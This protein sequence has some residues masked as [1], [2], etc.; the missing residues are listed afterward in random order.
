MIRIQVKRSFWHK[1]SEFLIPTITAPNP[2]Y[3][4]SLPNI[5]YDKYFYNYQ[6]R[7]LKGIRNH[8]YKNLGTTISSNYKIGNI[9]M[10]FLFGNTRF[11]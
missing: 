11:K 6:Y 3:M 1:L 9:H 2:Y 8:A 4:E 7:K 10:K 5:Q